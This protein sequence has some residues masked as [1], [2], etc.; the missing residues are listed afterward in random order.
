MDYNTQ[1]QTLNEQKDKIAKELS[2]LEGEF[3]LLSTQ[4]KEAN[5]KLK[6]IDNQRLIY[7]KSIEFLRKVEE[8]TKTKIKEGFENLVTYALR[9]VF[10]KDYKFNLEFKKRGNS[11]ELNYKVATPTSKEQDD[12][13]IT[14]GGGILDLISVAL[15][16]A[17][18]EKT[19]I[20]GFIALD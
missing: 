20:S 15:R 1:L 18:L 10:Q 3:N 13:L 7:K 4:I 8:S 2:S 17:L 12:P 6:E 9:F 19:K 5:S 11:Q 14:L 16:I